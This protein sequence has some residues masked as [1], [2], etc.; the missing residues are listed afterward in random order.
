MGC[1]APRHDGCYV[2]MRVVHIRV[3]QGYTPAARGKVLVGRDKVLA[4][5]DK[6][7]VGQDKALVG[8]GKGLVGRGKVLDQ[9]EVR[10]S[11]QTENRTGLPG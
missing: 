4:G 5:W 10:G 7:L 9:D 1:D 6:V 3:A 2:Q 8:P 11:V